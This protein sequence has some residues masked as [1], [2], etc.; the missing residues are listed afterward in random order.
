MTDQRLRRQQ[1]LT[2]EILAA[3]V[4]AMLITHL[5]NVRWLTGFTGSAASLVMTATGEVV[6]ITDFRYQFQA[7]TEVGG[8]ADVLIE[9]HSV[10]E[11]LSRVL[12]SF[13]LESVGVEADQ[14]TVGEAEKLVALGSWQLTPLRELIERLRQ[15]KDPGEV[16]L[17]RDAAQL[18]HEALAEVIPSIRVG[19]TELAVAAR[20]E[21]ALRLRGSEWHPFHTIVVSGPR[22]ALPHGQASE[23]TIE[24]GDLL[25][26]DFGAQLGGYCSDLTRTFV[27]GAR[28]DEKQREIHRIV[29]EAQVVAREQIHVGMTGVQADALAREVISGQGY[30]ADFGHS[31]GHGLGL[32]V[33]EMPRLA[34]NAE[35]R[36]PAGAVVTI[37]PGIYLQGWGGVRLEDDIWLSKDGPVLLSDGVIDLL[38]LK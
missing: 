25:L 2:A 26:I 35:A 15:I 13:N 8:T 6:L 31:L 28:P 17:I 4:D 33:H 7:S 21:A 29:A 24:A 16:A 3:G 12:Q 20:L 27:V 30:G 5:P 1:T 22:S 9:R 23:R 37:E 34:P 32:E 18:A 14:F 10:R 38:A 11:R 19:E 36:I